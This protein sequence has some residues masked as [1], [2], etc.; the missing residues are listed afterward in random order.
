MKGRISPPE[1]MVERAN[2]G[3]MPRGGRE[4]GGGG[5]GLPVS[6]ASKLGREDPTTMPMRASFNNLAFSSSPRLFHDSLNPQ[7]R[8][9]REPISSVKGNWTQEED[10]R[11]QK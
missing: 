8:K 11:L 9:N 1:E 10:D 5:G 3:I 2:G 6:S 7:R 4:G